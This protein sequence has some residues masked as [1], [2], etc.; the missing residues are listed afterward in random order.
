MIAK[1]LA[2]QEETKTIKNGCC[3]VILQDGETKR[4]PFKC[5]NDVIQNAI[6][7]NQKAI[8]E[9]KK[10]YKTVKFTADS[11]E[12]T[13]TG[14]KPNIYKEL[15]VY[16]VADVKISMDMYKTENGKTLPWNGKTVY[17]KYRPNEASITVT[18]ALNDTTIEDS[19]QVKFLLIKY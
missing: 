7:E 19:L 12:Q 5:I 17:V 2:I 4:I 8:E 1:K 15:F 3:F 16:N 10:E 11:L 9:S 6:E 13:I 14:I 18:L